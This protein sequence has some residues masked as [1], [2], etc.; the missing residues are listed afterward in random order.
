MIK[1]PVG[2][3]VG[4]GP[5]DIVLDGCVATAPPFCPQRGTAAP[6]TFR[7]MSI[8]A[9]RSSISA[10]AELLFDHATYRSRQKRGKTLWHF[11]QGSSALGARQ[12]VT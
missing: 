8:L 6:Y 1:M 4:L 5:G 3:E 10:S 12:F 11:G 9:K 2:M 7:P